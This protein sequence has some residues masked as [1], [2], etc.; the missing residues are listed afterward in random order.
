M[1]PKA[2]CNSAEG[3]GTT[4]K[5]PCNSAEGIG[6]TPKASCN[7]A[8]GFYMLSMSH[9]SFTTTMHHGNAICL[10]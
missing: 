2:S 7:S 1:T 4:P 5:A 3:I 6:T 9:T 10:F 8:E